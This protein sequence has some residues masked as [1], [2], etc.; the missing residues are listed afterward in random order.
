VLKRQNK[1]RCFR[2]EK[3]KPGRGEGGGGGRNRFSDRPRADCGF[4]P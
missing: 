1:Y 4:F 2:G 3:A